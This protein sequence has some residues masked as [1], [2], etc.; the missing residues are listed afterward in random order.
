LPDYVCRLLVNSQGIG[1]AEEVV[2]L[3]VV[4]VLVVVIMEGVMDMQGGGGAAAFP[5]M[6]LRWH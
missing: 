5:V 6:R 4:V 1:V 3:D 2:D